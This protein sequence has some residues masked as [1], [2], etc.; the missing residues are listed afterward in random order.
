MP[1][2]DAIAVAVIFVEGVTI[3][4]AMV[5]AD[6]LAPEFFNTWAM[7]LSLLCAKALLSQSR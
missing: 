5:A 1:E 3:Q 2:L 6:I 4:K 7:L